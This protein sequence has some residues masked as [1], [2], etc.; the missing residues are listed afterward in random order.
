MIQMSSKNTAAPSKK[1]GRAIWR[2]IGA[3][4]ILLFI[5]LSCVSFFRNYS[6]LNTELE[7]ERMIYVREISNQIS[8]VVFNR[9]ERLLSQIADSASMLG[10]I[11]ADSFEDVQNLYGDKQKQDYVIVLC[12]ENGKYYGIDGKQFPLQNNQMFS[13]MQ[14][15]DT[16]Q[17][18]F[19]KSTSGQDYWIFTHKIESQTIDGHTFVAVFELYNVAQFQS[20]LSLE[21][22][23]EQGFALILNQDGTV[24]LRPDHNSVNVGFNAINTFMSWG[25]PSDMSD[26]MRADLT[27]LK[28]N[29]F[30]VE[31][32]DAKW[33]ID[34]KNIKGSSEFVL[35]VTPIAVTSAGV[36]SS[37]QFSLLSI[38]GIIGGISLLLFA[39]VLHNTQLAKKRNQELYELK[40]Q[41]KTVE[42]KNDFLAKMSHDIRT[43][44]N[45]II[46]MNFLATTQV[47]ESDPVM[48]NLKNVD[49]SAKYLLGILND[50]LDMSKIESGK[51]E[52]HA[53]EFLMGELLTGIDVIV[54]AQASEKEIIYTET[55]QPNAQGCYIGDRLRIQQILMN[56]ISNALKFT[57]EGGRIT[58]ETALVETKD[59]IATLRFAV[60]DTG[61]GMTDEFM[62]SI[63][64]PFTQDGSN[65][66]HKYGGSG[67]GLSITK[68]FVDMMGGHIS[69][70]SKKD[71]GSTFVVLLPLKISSQAAPSIQAETVPLDESLLVGKRV[72]LVEDNNINMMIAKK[73]LMMF[74]MQIDESV[75]GKL[76]LERFLVSPAGYYSVIVSDI[77]MPEMDGYEL[78]EQIRSSSH[79]DAKLIPILAMSANAFDDDVAASLSHGMNAHLKKPMDV[80]ELKKALCMYVRDEVCHDGDT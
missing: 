63:F 33:L 54:N 53:D 24:N 32:S 43:P 34:Y 39:F 9:R 12:D 37:L 65:I 64:M 62:K 55:L 15:Q 47:R 10:C 16:S 68:S 58:V 70:T 21:L 19:E 30:Y 76:A 20:L 17:Y 61:I 23:D 13:Q 1:Q 28:D 41:A 42:S 31:L 49:T 80:G 71:K 78:A 73:V 8:T 57:P 51:M 74:G 77:R 27:N 52:L 46:G 56:L 79:P 50:I 22:F 69:V 45:A 5:G 59:D 66:S 25:M 35:V 60:S 67:L 29:R 6:R 18:F 48:E 14:E 75:N 72:L 44:L 2:P 7:Q 38:G 26:G 36:T 11:E 3:F 40:L 4:L